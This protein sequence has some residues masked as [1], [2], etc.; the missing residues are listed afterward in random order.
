MSTHDDPV[1]GR[2]GLQPK[3]VARR[4]EILDRAIEVFRERGADGTSLRRIAEA[5]GV[6]HA[7]LLHYF[8]SREQLLVAVYAHAE[9]RRNAT[10]D[11]S[12]PHGVETMI[13]SAIANVDVPGLVQL[14]TTLLA[15][16]LE[17]GNDVGREFFST[18]FERVREQLT[19]SFRNQQQ[20]GDIRR[21]V[22][23]EDLAALLIAA[24]DGLQIQ[25][26]LEPSLSLSDTLRTFGRLLTPPG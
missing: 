1:I 24:S 13:D 8:D 26:L 11:P 21:D 12:R 7:A 6:S 10:A 15:A 25:W 20:A 3:G 18:R 5:I 4:Q 19:T 23:A 22:P 16:S 17:A 2:R 9:E 14:Y